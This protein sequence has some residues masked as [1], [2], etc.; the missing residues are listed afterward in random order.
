MIATRCHKQGKGVLYSE[1]PCLEGRQGPLGGGAVQCTMRSKASWVMVMGLGH[2]MITDRWTDTI[3]NILFPQLRWWAVK[4]VSD[5]NVSG[6]AFAA[7]TTTNIL[8]Q[9]GQVIFVV[10]NIISA[11][12]IRCFTPIRAIVFIWISSPDDMKR[13]LDLLPNNIIWTCIVSIFIH[14]DF[15]FV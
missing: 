4:I 2:R 1:V 15:F 7:H 9:N 10:N 5:E 13:F 11:F 12:A 6:V 14:P 8:V 3:E